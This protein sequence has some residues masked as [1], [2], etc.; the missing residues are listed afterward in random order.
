[1]TTATITP[2]YV[3][4]PK[5][6]GKL[7]NINDV[8]GEKWFCDPGL[9]SS[10]R[11]GTPA[12]VEWSVMKF[13]DGKESKKITGVVHGAV[14]AQGIVTAISST[15]GRVN[16]PLPSGNNNTGREIFITGIVGRSMG[17]GK[18]SADDM[19]ILTRR[20]MAAWEIVAG[21]T[22]LPA[23]PDEGLND[24]VPFN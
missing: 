2:K 1:M 5:P 21:R 23:P 3:N 10:F 16:G 15:Q 14:S 6:G 20:A 12:T 9:L 13:N 19:D 24:P 18:F 8:N 7:G 17:S 4:Q 22:K 11:A